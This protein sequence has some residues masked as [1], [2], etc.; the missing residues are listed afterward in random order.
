[1]AEWKPK[2]VDDAAKEAAAAFLAACQAMLAFGFDGTML[3]TAI[4]EM[5]DSE[6]FDIGMVCRKIARR[7]PKSQNGVDK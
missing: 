4:D 5:K 1:M 2:P 7:I 6:K 3:L